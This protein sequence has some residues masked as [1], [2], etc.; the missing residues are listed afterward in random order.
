MSTHIYIYANACFLN[1]TLSIC[2]NTM[3]NEGEATG[4]SSESLIKSLNLYLSWEAT[5][6]R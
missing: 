6:R 1:E 5:T 3:A 2:A 4:K